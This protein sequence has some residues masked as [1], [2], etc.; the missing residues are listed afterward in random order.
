ME[1][2]E[3]AFF[4]SYYTIKKVAHVNIPPG[5]THKH[6]GKIAMNKWVTASDYVNNLGATTGFN[7]ANLT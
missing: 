1:P 3:S 2:S 6:L 4:K 7:F 5:G